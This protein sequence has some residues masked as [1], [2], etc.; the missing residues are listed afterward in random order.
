MPVAAE[1]RPDG[2]VRPALAVPAAREALGVGCCRR[3]CR[4]SGRGGVAAAAPQGG[5]GGAGG[6][7]AAG[8]AGRSCAGPRHDSHGRKRQHRRSGH[9]RRQQPGSGSRWDVLQHVQ[10]P[11]EARRRCG[12]RRRHEH[13]PRSTH[14]NPHQQ[15]AVVVGRD[16]QRLHD[17]RVAR[18]LAGGHVFTSRHPHQ[19][20]KEIEP[21]GKRG[22][23]SQQHVPPPHV[24][25]LVRKG[26]PP[27]VGREPR[28]PRPA[29][30]APPDS[31]TPTTCGTPTSGGR[32]HARHARQAERDASCDTGAR[33]TPES[34]V[35]RRTR[36]V[37]RD[38]RA[39]QHRAVHSDSNQPRDGQ[40][41][42]PGCRLPASGFRRAGWFPQDGHQQ[43]R[44]RTRRCRA[45][46]RQPSTAISAAGQE[47]GSRQQG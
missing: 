4:R 9:A 19:R 24:H 43:P 27:L 18:G 14:A 17:G 44:A 36:R 35:A 32:A 40:E 21:L 1:A 33:S 30:P 11:S 10:S 47:I 22:H 16:V 28:G 26:H 23:A 6:A 46:R 42:H 29:A 7:G 31:A 3:Q 37:Q 8:S 25:Q 13:R 41:V 38:R 34:G 15:P 12:G 5:A 20:V 39:H 2:G 45:L